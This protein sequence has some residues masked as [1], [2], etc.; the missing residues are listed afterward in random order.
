MTKTRQTNIY[1]TKK[2]QVRKKVQNDYD[3]IR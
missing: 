2:G 1:P 3:Q